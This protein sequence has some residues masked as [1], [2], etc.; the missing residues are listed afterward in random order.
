[1]AGAR[2][3]LDAGLIKL[4]G[5]CACE[6]FCGSVLELTGAGACEAF[7]WELF[8]FVGCAF[9]KRFDLGNKGCLDSVILL[10]S[11]VFL[12][13]KPLNHPLLKTV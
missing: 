4:A 8:E 3:V 2:E 5:A 7:R 9:A 12:E 10:L 13:N 6:A 1:M 11:G